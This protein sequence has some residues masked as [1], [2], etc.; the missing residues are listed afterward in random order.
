M[1]LGTVTKITENG[2]HILVEVNVGGSFYTAVISKVI[3]DAE[4]TALAK[5]ALIIN[6]LSNARRTGRNYENTFTTLVGTVVDIP[7]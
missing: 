3:F 5:Q 1:A 2:S 6:I 7:D 4:P